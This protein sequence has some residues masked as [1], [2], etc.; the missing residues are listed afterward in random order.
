MAAQI[1]YAFEIIDVCNNQRKLWSVSRFLI[2]IADGQRGNYL[3]DP[4]PVV[5]LGKRV[6]SRQPTKLVFFLLQLCICFTELIYD[7]SVIAG[8][9]PQLY[10]MGDGKNE[11]PRHPATQD[12][13]IPTFGRN[14]S[15]DK[16]NF[17]DFNIVVARLFSLNII[18]SH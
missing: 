13:Q 8:L 14:P 5:G 18:Y 4:E 15:T 2:N 11:K 1:V 16:F 9:S 7:L 6:N 10:K 3:V 17:F 12:E